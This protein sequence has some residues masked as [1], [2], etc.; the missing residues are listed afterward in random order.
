[1]KAGQLLRYLDDQIRAIAALIKQLDEVQVAFNAQF[2][3][4]KA[5]HD[6]QLQHLTEQVSQRLEA[7]S[8]ELRSAIDRQVLVE[9]QALVERRRKVEET[10]LPQRQQAADELLRKAQAEL[11]ELRALNPQLDEKEEIYKR[12]KAKLERRLEELNELIRQ[13]SKGLGVVWHFVAI[14]QVDRERQRIIGRL[15]GINESLYELRSEWQ[16]QRAKIEKQQEEYQRQWQMESI[17]VARLQSELDQLSDE[18]RREELALHRAIRHVL[19][20]LK[21]PSPCADPE[22]EAGLQEMVELNIQTDDYHDGLASV[23][24]FIGL[25]RGINSGLKAVRQ[26][27]EGLRKEQQMHS[28]YLPALNFSLPG[29]VQE[30]HQRWPALASRFADEKAIAAHPLEFAAQ[31][32]PLLEG[33]LSEPNIEAMFN[34]LDR[35]ITQA[36]KHW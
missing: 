2:D 22:L 10:Y 14:T 9:R 16:R 28:A 21:E 3:E 7:L 36:T 30:F 26:S 19:D 32:K 5:G 11:A 6:S 12:G 1:M 31:V 20:N 17:A 13:K 24:G 23:A 33:P 27:I 35:M 8:P 4:F 25:L 15:E 29:D 34:S 18:S